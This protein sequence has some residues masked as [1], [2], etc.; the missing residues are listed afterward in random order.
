MVKYGV[1][2]EVRTDVLNNIAE[3]RLQMVKHNAK[4]REEVEIYNAYS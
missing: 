4:K 1:L 2:F 3:L